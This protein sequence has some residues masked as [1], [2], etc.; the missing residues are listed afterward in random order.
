MRTCQTSR[1]TTLAKVDLLLGQADPQ[2][3]ISSFGRLAAFQLLLQAERGRFAAFQE[4]Y[5]PGISLHVFANS[6]THDI[7]RLGVLACCCQ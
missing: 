1:P 3:I 7:P 5:W 2:A 6:T 4:P